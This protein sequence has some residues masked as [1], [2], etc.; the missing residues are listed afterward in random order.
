MG[1]DQV[2]VN[3]VQEYYQEANEARKPIKR[4]WDIT[5]ALFNQQY[6][7]SQKAEWQHKV[8]MPK[9]S[10]A[11]RT[12]VALFK[13]ALIR[14]NDWFAVKTPM[15]SLE[16]FVPLVRGTLQYWI[17]RID[18]IN[19]FAEALHGGLLASL[20]ILKIYWVKGKKIMASEPRTSQITPSAP[21]AVLEE[22]KVKS[23]FQGS[24]FLGER[25]PAPTQYEDGHLVMYPVDPY[26]FWM[27]PTGRGKYC[28]EEIE[29]DLDDLIETGSDKGYDMA[30]IK[31]IQNDFVKTTE[32][33]EEAK[34]K[35]Q[36]EPLSKPSFRK[37]VRIREFWGDISKADGTKLH[38]NVTCSVA[39]ERFLIR[40]PTPN[41]FWHKQVP[42]R[43]G[44]IV[45]KPFSVF[46]KGF[47]ED[48]HGIQL[49]ITELTG[50][51]LDSN[52]LA[53][54]RAFELDMDLVADP[55]EFKNGIW[56]G[57]T[58]KKNGG[59]GGSGRMIQD[60][61]VGEFVPQSIRILLELDRTF[62]NESIITEFVS[63]GT[64]TKGRATATEVVSKTNQASTLIQDIAIDVENFVMAPVLE[65]MFGVC[66]QYQ[67]DFEDERMAALVDQD[68]RTRVSLMNEDERK[69]YIDGK[70]IFKCTGISGYINRVSQIQ[71][72]GMLTQLF[73]YA[74]DLVSWFK[75]DKLLRN[76]LEWLNWDP[77]DIIYTQEEMKE[78]QA[79]APAP[80]PGAAAGT[81]RAAGGIPPE[82]AKMLGM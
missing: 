24:G 52:L 51:I 71:K 74:P 1:P 28:I 73:Q 75:K 58:Y 69:S 64:G 49:A 31:E 82:I 29:V 45:R 20:V 37:T 34:R 13:Q 62:Q 48:L 47:V 66:L 53:T 68:L 65:M 55:E 26:K 23:L 78:Q 7:F 59:L 17:E 60:L 40:K 30:V 5:W 16:P 43:W 32:Q 76:I 22:K 33:I 79:V 50:A 36:S 15:K 81:P 61:Q 80:A 39:N 70:F 19:I 25:A 11:I 54:V 27:D 14:S 35:G 77:E 21:V 8:P 3:A 42:Y 72:F 63:G 4:L 41:P 2:I 6:D 9:I 44:P 10:G 57:K 46:H 12:A 56:P 18:F 67:R 38:K